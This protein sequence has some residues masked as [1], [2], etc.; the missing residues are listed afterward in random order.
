MA[1]ACVLG[2]YFLHPR[3]V[4]QVLQMIFSIPVGEEFCSKLQ[5]L[6]RKSP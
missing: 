3:V 2:I 1:D 5:K 4:L 6:H